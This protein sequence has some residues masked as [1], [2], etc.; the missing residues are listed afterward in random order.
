[1]AVVYAI[2]GFQPL[3]FSLDPGIDNAFLLAGRIIFAAVTCLLIVLFQ[4]KGGELK[5]VFQNREVLRKEIPATVFLFADWGLYL[6]GIRT[7]RVLECSMG[8]YI[9]PIVMVVFGAVIF[10]EKIGWPH[11]GSLGL[12]AVGIALSS[13][14]FGRFP[15]LTVLLALSFAIYSA[16][17]KSLTLDSLVSTTAEIL[18][19]LP[20]AL[21][22]ILL[23]RTGKNG[24]S[25]LTLTRQLFLLGSGLVT[26]IPM[27]FFARGL[28][29]LPL[30]L[31]GIMQYVSPTLGIV[32]SRILGES[33]TKEKLLSFSFIWAGVILYTVYELTVKKRN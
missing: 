22:F 19:M 7:G 26:G 31:T 8:Y 33:F 14:G 13:R 30:S 17:K 6:L 4:G 11:L 29:Y 5:A 16:I 32:C 28:S 2:W 23:F 25:G 21:L 10:R 20:F 27:V 1:M 9:M 24:L 3:Y 18:I 12:I 15:Y